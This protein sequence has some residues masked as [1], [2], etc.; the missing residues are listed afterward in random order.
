MKTFKIEVKELVYKTI[1]IQADSYEE[2]I[3]EARK[4]YEDDFSI[5]EKKKL[6]DEIIEYLY[7]DE[8][9]HYEEEG[10]ESINHIFHKLVK[11]KALN[12]PVK[13]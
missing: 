7:K 12:N 5:N 9:R 3:T 8:E 4:H 10:D 6:I 2:A 13:D 1:E 11:L